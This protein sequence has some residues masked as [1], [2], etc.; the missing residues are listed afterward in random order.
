MIPNRTDGIVFRLQELL[1]E[2]GQAPLPPAIADR[3]DTF[4]SLLQ[5]WNARTNLTA[6]RSDDAILRR[7]FVESI[8]C[9]RALPAGI[10]SLIDFGSGAGFPGL[11]IALCRPEIAV[12]VAESQGKKAAFLREAV[13]VLELP[14]EVYAARAESNI[15]RFDCVTLRAVDRMESALGSAAGLVDHGGWLAL[16]TTG[17]LSAALLSHAGSDFSWS[18]MVPLPSAADRI[19]LLGHRAEGPSGA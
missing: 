4:F 14:V 13:R 15:R 19:L 12:I 6:I 18:H 11:P 5:R 2:S 9:A 3:F 17:D 16:L 1:A 7:H 8:V 10:R